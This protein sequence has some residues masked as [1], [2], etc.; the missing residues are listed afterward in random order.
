[1]TSHLFTT[2]KISTLLFAFALAV[3]LASP[4]RATAQIG[5][6]PRYRL[7]DLGTFGGPASSFADLNNRG[8]VVGWAN[9]PTTDP[10]CFFA[11]DNCFTTHAFQA[12]NGA[13]TDLGVLPGGDSS[14][15]CCINASGLVIAG[16]SETGEFDPMYGVPILRPVL[17]R[18]GQMIDLGLLPGGG[19]GG[20]AGDVNDRGQVVGSVLNTVPDPCNII[21]L[22]TQIRAFLWQK[23]VMQY[24]GTLGGPEADARFI[25][26]QGQVT[27]VSYTN[28]INPATGCPFLHPYFWQNGTML[29][30]G[31]LGGD[32]AQP[33]SLNEMGQVVG[34]SQLV[35]GNPAV[36]PFLWSKGQLTDLG[37]LGGNEGE[38]ESINGRGDIVGEAD[39]PGPTPQV[40]HAVLWKRGQ[41]IDLGALPG[42]ACSHAYFVNSHG[43]IVGSS[44]DHELCGHAGKHAVL[45]EAGEPTD[46]N[47]LIPP[48][49]SLQLT[50]AFAINDRGEIAGFGVPPDCAL[51]DQAACGHAYTLIP[52]GV[53]EECVNTALGAATPFAIP[54]LSNLSPTRPQTAPASPLERFRDKMRQRFHLMVLGRVTSN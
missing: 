42:D 4:A 37:T 23:G 41:I 49:A 10:L 36:H 35:A 7:V 2:I 17:W 24:L 29:D 16:M 40:H 34:I 48:G 12:R 15:A 54:S 18:N 38:T 19:L 21:G 13:I 51:Q 5:Q 53:G 20:G 28:S 1:M 50:F 47:T 3:Q 11:Q 52:C 33:Q 32:E 22:P 45:W 9:A 25:N 46:L 14:A 8:T 6:E 31:T 44:T 39:L 26:D 43:Q 30:I 27:G